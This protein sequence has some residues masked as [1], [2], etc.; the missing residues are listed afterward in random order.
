MPEL[1]LASSSLGR[2]KLLTYLK[3]PFKIIQSNLDED[4][5][6]GKSPLETIRL[7]AK[8]KGEKVAKI[9]LSSTNYKLPTT[10]Y[11]II[12]ADSDAILENEVIGKAKN[13][14]EGIKIL[15]KLSAKTH[16]FATSVYI[17]KI[18]T[19]IS[20]NI[21]IIHESTTKS[22]VTFRKIEREEIEYYLDKTDFTRFAG[23]YALVSAQD[24]ITKVEGS[25][26]NVIGLPL[27]V[28]IPVF[29]SLGI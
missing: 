13:K 1:I 8:L 2:K 7:R 28:I 21:Q 15:Q 6:I 17:I 26:S 20:K 27:E 29:K 25:L 12:S 3:V 18:D 14:K 16:L 22:F 5:I 4:K 24:F 9:I 19:K 11:I 10:N 23:S